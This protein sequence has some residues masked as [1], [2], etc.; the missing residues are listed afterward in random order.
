[1]RLFVTALTCI[2]VLMTVS[3]C[4]KGLRGS[5]DVSISVPASTLPA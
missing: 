5:R 1:M 3:G 2:M 4:S